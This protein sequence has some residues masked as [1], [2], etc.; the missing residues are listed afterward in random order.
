VTR[1]ESPALS[2]NCKDINPS[3]DARQFGSNH[4]LV[5][6]TWKNAFQAYFKPLSNGRVF[7]SPYAEAGQKP[8]H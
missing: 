2:R 7:L 3:Q 8:H 6:G 5:D 4:S 1:K